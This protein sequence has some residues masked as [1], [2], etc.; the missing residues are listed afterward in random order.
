MVRMDVWRRISCRRHQPKKGRPPVD[1]PVAAA[2][3][4]LHRAVRQDCVDD[5]PQRP[6]GSVLVRDHRLG[7]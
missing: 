5:A 7:L 1:L 3:L 6:H 2:L 4:S